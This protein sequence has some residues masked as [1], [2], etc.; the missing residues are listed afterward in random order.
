M[1]PNPVNR[2]LCKEAKNDCNVIFVMECIETQY[3]AHLKSNIE[4][5]W[6]LFWIFYLKHFL[7]LL[8]APWTN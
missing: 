1:E 2:R 8:E 5:D 3:S 6:L 4:Q 7:S